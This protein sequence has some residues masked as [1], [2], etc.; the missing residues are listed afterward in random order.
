MR[1]PCLGPFGGDE[2]DGRMR[3]KSAVSDLSYIFGL[4][5]PPKISRMFSPECSGLNARGGHAVLRNCVDRSG[6]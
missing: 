5:D 1:A 4:L 6:A 2:P 3:I